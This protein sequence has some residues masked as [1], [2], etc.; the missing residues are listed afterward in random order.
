MKVLLFNNQTWYSFS[1]IKKEMPQLTTP[2]K[3]ILQY[4]VPTDSFCDV[5]N[6]NSKICF[7]KDYIDRTFFNKSE[8]KHHVDKNF[9]KS[10]EKINRLQY[11]DRMKGM[12]I[13]ELETGQMDIKKM[14][15]DHLTEKQEIREKLGQIIAQ[16]NTIITQNHEEIAQKNTII[17]QNHE[18]IAQNNTI[19]IQN[20]HIIAQNH[21]ILEQNIAFHRTLDHVKESITHSKNE[22]KQHFDSR[23]NLRSHDKTKLIEEKKE[24]SM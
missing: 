21:Q 2:I 19:I 8:R 1:E 18:E 7:E 10:N 14:M 23:Y 5:G 6:K 20:N 17:T 22:I 3:F 11:N 12:K 13:R 16:K 9:S 15:F 4:N 24:K